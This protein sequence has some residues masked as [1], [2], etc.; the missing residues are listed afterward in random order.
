M[1]FIDNKL[2]ERIPNFI[3]NRFFII[4]FIYSIYLIFFN[5]YN[6]LS[7]YK[8]IDELRSLKKEAMFYNKEIASIKAKQKEIFANKAS[9]EQFAREKYWMK[10]DS[11]E[12]YIVFPVEK[13]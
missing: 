1:K 2:L 12:I 3:R 10:K 7:Q 6:F 13:N 9:L 4:A 8:L 11:E 5:Q